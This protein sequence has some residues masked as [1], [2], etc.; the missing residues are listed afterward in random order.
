MN[1]AIATP[2]HVLRA[3]EVEARNISHLSHEDGFRQGYAVGKHD[4]QPHIQRALGI[5][6]LLGT[7][8]GVVLA[9]VAVTL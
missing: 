1:A 6:V 9:I 8:F 5:G 4:V 7:G 2:F 3:V